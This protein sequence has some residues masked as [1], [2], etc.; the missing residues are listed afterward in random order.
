MHADKAAYPYARAAFDV[1]HPAGLS[2]AWHQAL[3]ALAGLVREQPDLPQR[4]HSGSVRVEDITAPFAKADASL[5]RFVEILCASGRLGLAPGVAEWFKQLWDQA[6][7]AVTVEVVTPFPLSPAM[8][9]ALERKATARFGKA[10][11]VESRVDPELKAGA[12]LRAGDLEIENTLD[13]KIK[14]LFAAVIS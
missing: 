12:V 13:S 10:V 8:T 2:A 1:A 7:A 5:G 11:V 4:L 14:A 9:Q 6:A 3:L